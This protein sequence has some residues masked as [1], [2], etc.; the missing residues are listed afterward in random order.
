MVALLE[1]LIDGRPKELIYEVPDL[2]GSKEFLLLD[3]QPAG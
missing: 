2:G 3:V 1:V